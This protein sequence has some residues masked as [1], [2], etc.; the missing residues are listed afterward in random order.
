MIQGIRLEGKKEAT[1]LVWTLKR[2]DPPKKVRIPLRQSADVFSKAR[3]SPGD[4]IR[5]GEVLADPANPQSVFIHSSVTGTVTAITLVPHPFLG[6]VE[7]VEIETALHEQKTVEFGIERKQWEQLSSEELL[8][9]FQESGLL[10]MEP[11][12]TPVHALASRKVKTL[13]LNACEPEPYQT[14][15]HALMMSHSPEILKGGEILRKA[16]GAERLLVV[17]QDDKLEVAE[18]IKSKI[19]LSKWKH[20][21]IEIVPTLYP[22]GKESMIRRKYAKES[23]SI[24]NVATAYAVYE[25]V[26]NQKPF[27][28]RV[29]TVGG[30]CVLEPKNIWARVGMDFEAAIK[31]GK[32]FLRPPGKVIM[33][34]PMAGIAQ[35]N[36][37]APVTAGVQ[38]VLAL[39][40]EL[41]RPR[42]EESCIRSGECVTVCPVEIHPAFI[43]LAV[44]QGQMDL[45]RDYGVDACIECGN[46]TYICPSKRP[47]ADLLRLGK[48]Q[49]LSLASKKK[50]SKKRDL[51]FLKEK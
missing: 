1:L 51:F 2:L 38:A 46:C 8:K 48:G 39:P 15:E 41:T 22:H 32:G 21:E 30:E 6:A 28:E 43:T 20:V 10:D 44:E 23:A 33:G 19:F 25:A 29:V 16:C 45:A 49:R 4:K 11:D 50:R 27:I 12:M 17:I 13:I 14:C 42:T 34:G 35:E 3:V 9:L 24:F 7:A 5:T 37:E 36:L 47:M 40:E 26:V 18:T 31:S